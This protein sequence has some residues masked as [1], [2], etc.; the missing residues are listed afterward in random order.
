MPHHAQG[1]HE[2][3]CSQITS[4]KESLGNTASLTGNLSDQTGRREARR[5]ESKAVLVSTVTGRR[6]YATDG[7]K[8]GMAP[9]LSLMRALYEWKWEAG[10]AIALALPSVF[11]T[12]SCLSSTR[13]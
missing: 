1:N 8:G 13:T 10:S 7:C 5:R 12:G 9:G 2:N 4:P 3:H 6:G 11:S